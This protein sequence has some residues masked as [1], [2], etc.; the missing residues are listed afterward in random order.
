MRWDMLLSQITEAHMHLGTLISEI[1]DSSEINEI[2]TMIQLGHIYAHLNRFWHGRNIAG[3]NVDAPY[4]DEN[5]AFPDDV[6]LT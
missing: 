5:S 3:G 2:D 4:T 1:E 6:T